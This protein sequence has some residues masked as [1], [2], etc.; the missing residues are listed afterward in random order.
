MVKHCVILL[1]AIEKALHNVSAY[2][3]EQGVVLAQCKSQSK[4]NEVSTVMALIELL[5][6]KGSIITTDAMHCLKK[7]ATTID[8]KGGDYV[9]QVKGNQ[10][11]LEQKIKA[12]FHKTRR[13]DSKLIKNN[14][15]T[16]ID[17]GHGRIEERRY[18][19]LPVTDWLAQR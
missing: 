5:E 3:L 12:S 11:K 2:A 17:N 18:S 4:K 19:Q 1:M 16:T 13:E 8:K 15:L 6:L 10:R 14:P 7:V 9:L